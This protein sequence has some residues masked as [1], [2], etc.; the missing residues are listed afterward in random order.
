MTGF[1][2]R[3]RFK[4][5]KVGHKA[6]KYVRKFGLHMLPSLYEYYNPMTYTQAQAKGKA[7][8]E[9]LRAQGYAVWQS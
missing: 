7:L 4:N 3:Q 2:P 1:D 9:K 6:N 8:T 5:H